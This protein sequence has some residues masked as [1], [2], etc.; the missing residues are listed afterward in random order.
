MIIIFPLVFLAIGL[1]LSGGLFYATQRMR[2]RLQFIEDAQACKA[3][4]PVNGIVKLNGIV[5]AVHPNELLV[6]PI[7]QKPCVYYRFVIEEHQQKIFSTPAKGSNTTGAAGSWVKIIEDVQAVPMV[8][9]DETGEVAIDP[10]NADMDF[11]V[12]RTHANLFSS[13]PK[14]LEESLVERYKIVTKNFFLSKQMRYTEVVVA[15]DAEVFVVGDCEVQD[16]KATLAKKDHPLLITFRKEEQV[17]RN[18][19]ISV[20]I[21]KV[22]AVGLLVLFSAGAVGMYMQLAGNPTSNPPPAAKQVP[23][24]AKAAR[25]A[26]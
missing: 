20:T 14:E 8:L 18:G 4:S 11:Q 22:L 15:Q 5:K 26:K 21:M 23:A 16:G 10:K 17:L 2:G 19:N 6:S 9:A 25:P 1:G 24:K 13:L 3:G 7:E 12:N